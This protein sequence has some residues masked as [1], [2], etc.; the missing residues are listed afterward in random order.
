MATCK[1]SKDCRDGYSCIDMAKDND[2]GAAVIQQDPEITSVC[3]QSMT[4][5]EQPEEQSDEV[6]TGVFDES[7]AGG[8]AG[9]AEN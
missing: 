8:G 9:G 2:W 1:R 3:I 7:P 6:C 4:F 5:V